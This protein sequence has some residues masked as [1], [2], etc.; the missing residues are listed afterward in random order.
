MK[1]NESELYMTNI[2]QKNARKTGTIIENAVCEYL[3]SKGYTIIMQNYRCKL[4]EIDIIAKENAVLVFIEVKYRKNVTSGYPEES[5]NFT[6]QRKIINSSL[7]YIQEN[8]IFLNTNFRYDVV[9]ITG[10]KVKIIRNAFTL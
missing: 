8:H 5:V 6:K 3:K 1:N 10:N 4:G 7:K 9:S 2:I